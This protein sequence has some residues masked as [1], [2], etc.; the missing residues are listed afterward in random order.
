MAKWLLRDQQTQLETS[1][2]HS[3]DRWLH[4]ATQSLSSKAEAKNRTKDK[5][6]QEK[7]SSGQSWGRCEHWPAQ[8]PGWGEDWPDTQEVPPCFSSSQDTRSSL[9]LAS[10]H[11]VHTEMEAKTP[12]GGQQTGERVG[13][14]RGTRASRKGLR[15]AEEVVPR[16]GHLGSTPSTPFIWGS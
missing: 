9:G 3:R 4:L 14:G 11:Q 12:C 5:R 15:L 1:L 8:V 2:P 13:V 10:K 6:G 16:P 7:S